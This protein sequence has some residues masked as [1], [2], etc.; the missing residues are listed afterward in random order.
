MSKKREIRHLIRFAIILI[1]LC[2]FVLVAVS[3][4]GIPALVYFLMSV[5][6]MAILCLLIGNYTLQIEYLDENNKKLSAICS[7]L[8]NLDSNKTRSFN[9]SIHELKNT[10]HNVYNLSDQLIENTRDKELI[11]ITT[12]NIATL[13]LCSV[14]LMNLVNNVL[15]TGKLERTG[16]MNPNYTV[17]KL[18]QWLK[19]QVDIYKQV[20]YDLR[21]DLNIPENVPDYI[22]SDITFLSRVVN[23][24]VNNASKFSPKYGRVD[25]SIVYTGQELKLQVRDQGPGIQD[26]SA[27]FNTYMTAPGQLSGF[28]LGLPIVKAIA[29]VMN[30]EITV[31]NG[32]DTGCTFTFRFPS[33]VPNQSQIDEFEKAQYIIDQVEKGY[34]NGKSVLVVED[35][36]INRMMLKSNLERLGCDC[37]LAENGTAGLEILEQALP[38][39]ILLDIS[40]PELNGNEFLYLAKKRKRSSTIPIILISASFD[41][42]PAG[43]LQGA[44]GILEKPYS[45]EALYKIIRPYFMRGIN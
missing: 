12:E 38:D 30:G 42:L 2:A 40:M 14:S 31:E 43:T 7:I 37:L 20:Y 10:I 8:T 41:N 36:H 24:L 26:T 17:I 11:T 32:Q 39:L 25:V 45:K 13:H 29:N 27:I 1:F 3:I 4:A 22:L 34:C 18:K 15:D 9:E 21:M 28:G 44:A 6:T 23:N 35:N 19:S 16:E 5:I 33:L